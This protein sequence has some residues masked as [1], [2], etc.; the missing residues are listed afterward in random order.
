PALGFWAV[1][2]EARPGLAFG[3]WLMYLPLT[4]VGLLVQTGAEELA[5][6]GYLQQQVA[7]RFRHPVFWMVIP[8]VLFGFLHYDPVSMGGNAL[9]IVG[10]TTMFGLMAADLTARSGNLGAAWGMHFANNFFALAVVAVEDTITGLAL[11][12]TAYGAGDADIPLAS[13]ALDFVVLILAWGL[14]RRVVRR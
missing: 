13:L 14:C 7:A 2:N 10:A 4:L 1:T 3:P 5:F 8:S 11:Y 9:I 6:R 12:R